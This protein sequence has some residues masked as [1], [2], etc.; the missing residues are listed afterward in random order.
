[1][2][3]VEGGGILGGG[4]WEAESFPT[5]G[6]GA[7]QEAAGAQANGGASRVSHL[8]S[9]PRHALGMGV[10]FSGA[11]A[12]DH[13]GLPL[14]AGGGSNSGVNGMRGGAL[15]GKGG[16][17][18]SIGREGGIGVGIEHL[19][20]SGNEASARGMGLAG[21]SDTAGGVAHGGGRGV[22]NGAGG[23]FTMGR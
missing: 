4:L 18:H 17:R 11:S 21:A 8:L 9:Y 6:G 5:V 1:M 22:G 23:W 19:G 10:K 12:F 2:G 16:L 7:Q 14:Q 3:W 15:T 20:A 13:G